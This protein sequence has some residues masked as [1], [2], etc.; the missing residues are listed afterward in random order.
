MAIDVM[1]PIALDVTALLRPGIY[2]LRSGGRVVYVGK[3]KCPLVRIAAH[4]S[5]ARRR[6]PTWMPFKGVVFDSVHVIPSH[7]DR[8]DALEMDVIA[9]LQPTQNIVV[10]YRP[11]TT[12]RIRRL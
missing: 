8:I 3:S 12:S 2:I 4:R 11:H 7:P 6:A 9:Q 10:P 1:E 5:L